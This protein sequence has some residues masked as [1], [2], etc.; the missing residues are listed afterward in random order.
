MLPYGTLSYF[1]YLGIALIPLII[2]QLFGKKFLLYQVLLSICFLGLTF[3]D[4]K[5]GGVALVSFGLWQLLLVKGYEWYRQTKEKNS[6]WIFII[7]LWLSIFPLFL[8]KCKV[9]FLGFLG[10][11]YL[12]FRVVNIVMEL[13]DGLIKKVPVFDFLYFLYFFPTI[14]SGPIDRF[15]RFQKELKEPIK[16]YGKFLNR[17][18]FCIF[19]GFLYK[20]I[21]AYL[22]DI[23]CVDPLELEIMKLPS[24]LNLAGYMYSYGFHLFFDFAGYSF[25]AIGISYLMGYEIPKNFHLPFASKNIKE[26]WNRWHMSL[27]LWFRDFVYMRLV[28]WLMKKKLIKSP[29]KISNLGY[30]AL[31]LLMG[32]WHGFTWYLIAYG[33]YHAVLMCVTDIWIRFKKKHKGLIPENKGMDFLNIVLTMHAALIGFLIFSGIF[34]QLID[35]K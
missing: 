27:S 5:F 3:I 8:V 18:I 28:Y 16:D 34:D 11:S 17:G 24:F 9:S 6:T 21:I 7:I 35:S 2:A 20:F 32:I 23:Y 19:Q 26:F 10:I 1:I 13:R 25:F 15:R 22:L 30:F 31:F 33:L 14:S 12:T 4:K 29:I